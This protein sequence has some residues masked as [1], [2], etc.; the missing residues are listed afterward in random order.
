[1]STPRKNA[2]GTRGKPFAPGNPGKPK[3]ARNRATRALEEL[4]GENAE[5][6]ARAVITAA[7]KG[8][9]AAARLVLERVI[10]A[11]KDMPVAIDLPVIA[12]ASGLVA[13][14]N[15][16]LAA[17]SAGDI[18]PGE[19]EAVMGLLERQRRLVETEDLAQRIADLERGAG[20]GE[21]G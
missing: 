5:A 21:A 17:V 14:G 7:K 11:R 2:T 3:G 18:T 4:L 8:D 16:L 12:D 20:N 10:P 15:A 1:M 6:V 13:A 9:T 19:A